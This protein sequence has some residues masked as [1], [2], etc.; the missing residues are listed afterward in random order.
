[1]TVNE[2]GANV[3]THVRPEARLA[4]K[5]KK[6]VDLVKA[7]LVDPNLHTDARMRLQRAITKLLATGDRPN[8]PRSWPQ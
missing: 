7:A 5:D 8:G 2:E 4:S 1:M 6:R 3:S